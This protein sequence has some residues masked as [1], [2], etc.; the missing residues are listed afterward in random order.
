MYLNLSTNDCSDMETKNDD[1]S[2]TQ[3]EQ[4]L[5]QSVLLDRRSS[6]YRLLRHNKNSC[7]LCYRSE[8]VR[9]SNE[10]DQS[11]QQKFKLDVLKHVERLANPVWTKQSKQALLHLKQRHF[12]NFQDVCLY[13]E[14]CNLMNSTGYRLSAR[15][16][17][18]ELFLDLNFNELLNEDNEALKER[19]FTNRKVSPKPKS[20]VEKS[21]GDVLLV[22]ASD[23]NR[24][25]IKGFEIK[26][27][28]RSPEKN[29]KKLTYIHKKPVDLTDLKLTCSENKFPIKHSVNSVPQS[30]KST[31][32]SP[33]SCGVFTSDTSGVFSGD[34]MFVSPNQRVLSN[35]LDA[36][37]RLVLEEESAP[38]KS[39]LHTDET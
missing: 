35:S 32:R 4:N 3:S 7:L 37:K 39:T 33:D 18:Q 29:I 11:E 13:S 12:S 19:L 17:L 1:Y 30:G 14:V 27:F 16:F 15:R 21:Q 5:S 28:S 25:V 22:A 10:E 36:G 8:K 23:S 2:R 31:L 9:V 20:P 38:S 26:E 24:N 6:S 34:A